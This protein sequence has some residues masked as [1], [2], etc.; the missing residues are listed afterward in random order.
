MESDIAVALDEYARAALTEYLEASQAKKDADARRNKA[1]EILL[2]LF[3]RN[4]A[5]VGTV[6]GIP[7]CRLVRTDREI[8]DTE[9]LRE[10]QPYVFT[11]YRKMSTAYYVREIGGAK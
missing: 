3:R 1:H 6:D 9:R 2:D 5:D 4:G 10:E 7:V 8:T 11:R